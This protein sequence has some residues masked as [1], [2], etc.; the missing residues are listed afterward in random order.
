[1][2]EPGP[3]QAELEAVAAESQ[4]LE[5][6]GRLDA[7]ATREL[8]DRLQAASKR[9][10]AETQAR[11]DSLRAEIDAILDPPKPPLWFRIVILALTLAVFIGV[12][13]EVTIGANFIL[14]LG[15]RYRAAAPWII[16][17]LL[18]VMAALLLVAERRSHFFH[19]LYPNPIL[20]LLMFPLAVAVGA[21]ALAFA[22]MGWAAVY[23]RLAGAP[24]HD[25]E[26][27]LV[28]LEDVHP[29][30]RCIQKGEVEWRGE[31]AKVCV[32]AHIVGP[33]PVRGDRLRLAG[34]QST[35]GLYLQ[36]IEKR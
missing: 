7:A 25:V 16:G 2:N 29:G 6:E 12:M 8:S 15:G 3:A 36:R 30:S 1:M 9:L 24:V 35:A 20:R 34:L 32:S 4:R 11:I 19:A 10:E 23:G 31:Q 22:P 13:L 27:R 14:A 33:R 21:G 26:G 18:A 17:A 5:R 28:S